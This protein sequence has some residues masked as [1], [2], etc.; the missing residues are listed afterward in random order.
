MGVKEERK[1]DIKYSKEEAMAR[2]IGL[3]T[4]YSIIEDRFE[5]IIEEHQLD[6][7]NLEARDQMI[8]SYMARYQ[9][10]YKD[11]VWWYEDELAEMDKIAKLSPY[12]LVQYLKQEKEE[13]KRNIN[14]IEKRQKKKL[15]SF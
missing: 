15:K 10:E 13:Q 8:Y 3:E 12:E 1:L 4:A 11:A 7:E 9:L 14:E 2:A 6:Y 5:K